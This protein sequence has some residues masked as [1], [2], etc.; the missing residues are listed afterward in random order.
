MRNGDMVET[1]MCL[2]VAEGDVVCECEGDELCIDCS[3][4]ASWANKST[5]I[6]TYGFGCEVKPKVGLWS[7][8]PYDKNDY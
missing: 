6:T 1:F 4:F 3:K 8:I 7:W 5:G 2:Q